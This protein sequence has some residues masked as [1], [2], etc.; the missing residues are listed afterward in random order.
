[1]RT[2]LLLIPLGA[3]CWAGGAY[4]TWKLNPARST[5]P[6]Q[7]QPKRLVVRVEA[8]SK[9]EVVTVDR[10]EDNGQ[11]T[12]SSTILYLD[13]AVRDFQGTTCS[14]S[15]T[16]RRL[17]SQTVEILRQCGGGDWERLVQHLARQGEELVVEITRQR[18]GHR[19]EERLLLEKQ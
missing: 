13:G 14:G 4:G 7:T 10:T 5:F 18:S 3:A 2:V 17:D 12:S 19:S 9:G 1:M 16:S 8:H 6:G 15:Q 11:S